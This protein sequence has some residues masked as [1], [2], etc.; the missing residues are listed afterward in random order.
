MSYRL[1]ARHRVQVPRKRRD[2]AA[3]ASSTAPS[4]TA[5]DLLGQ[6]H[7]QAAEPPIIPG[8]RGPAVSRASLQANLAAAASS[9]ASATS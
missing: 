9:S 4:S 5:R 2:R 6:I 7:A 1:K 3:Q 8:G